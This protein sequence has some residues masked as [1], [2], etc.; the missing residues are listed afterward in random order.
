M[1]VYKRNYKSYDGALTPAWS[2]FWILPR[3]AWKGLF[4][5]RFLTIFYVLCLFYPLGCLLAIYL[6]AN[7]GFLAQFIRVPDGGILEIGPEF[8]LT[9]TRVQG[10]FAFLMTAF[11]GPGLVS[12]D[13]V[14]NAL[15]L[16]FC[17]PFTRVEYVLGK[18]AVIAVLLS[19]ITW[20]PG[21]A[22]FLVHSSLMG[23]TWM[24][25]NWWLANSMVLGSVLWIF[26]VSMLALAISAWVR[27]KIVAGAVLALWFFLGAG[28]AQ[29]INSAIDTQKGY[30]LD[31][32]H[33]INR[34]WRDLF[35]IPERVETITSEEAGASIA[36]LCAL[37]LLLLWKKI[38]A[39]EV[40]K[41]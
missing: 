27:W 41:G 30:W 25:D 20:I 36:I 2:R 3:H 4:R 28:L 6:N 34:L 11:V 38:R 15:P 35:D 40:V 17:R 29:A 19:T 23:W 8:F 14:N 32:G 21:V 24:R 16:Y 31:L 1:A 5:Q 37:C 33:G 39:Y 12:P 9:Y 10:T 7:L 13:L 22:L 18:M 26:A